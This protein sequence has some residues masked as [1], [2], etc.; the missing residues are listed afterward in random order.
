MPVR[1]CPDWLISAPGRG[2]GWGVGGFRELSAFRASHKGPGHMGPWALS[3]W[4]HGPLGPWALGP[5]GPWA[6]GPKIW[7][8]QN[9][10]IDFR[11][12]KKS[13]DLPDSADR[14]VSSRRYDS[15]DFRPWGHEVLAQK[16]KK[17]SKRSPNQ[18]KSNST[19]YPSRIFPLKEPIGAP[20]W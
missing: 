14:S 8:I 13:T 3:P 15:S 7:K 20:H 18:P 9:P 16:G 6:Q 2:L 11:L 5:L 10:K 4:A 17:R 19:N 12:R 1:G